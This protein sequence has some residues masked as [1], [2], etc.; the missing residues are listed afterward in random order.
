MVVIDRLVLARRLHTSPSRRSR[1]ACAIVDEWNCLN[2]S[3]ASDLETPRWR[4]TSKTVMSSVAWAS[5]YASALRISARAG[6][7]GAV[8]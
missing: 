1:M 8:L 7:T 3:S 6:E 2:L 4:T 5:I